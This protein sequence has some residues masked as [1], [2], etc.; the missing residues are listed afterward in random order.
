MNFTTSK[1]HLITKSNLSVNGIYY[2]QWRLINILVV[3]W[4]YAVWAQCGL[5][6]KCTICFQ[7]CHNTLYL[8]R[9]NCNLFVLRHC[10]LLFGFYTSDHQKRFNQP[11]L[12]FSKLKNKTV[13]QVLGNPILSFSFLAERHDT[14]CGELNWDLWWST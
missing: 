13:V 1:E 6:T 10:F 5:G 11:G 3:T 4:I 8:Q 14:T 7:H 2:T 9:K 12:N